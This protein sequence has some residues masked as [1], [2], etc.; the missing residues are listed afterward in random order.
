V[1]SFSAIHGEAWLLI[2]FSAAWLMGGI[3]DGGGDC[4]REMAMIA[5]LQNATQTY[6]EDIAA[7]VR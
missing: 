2:R 7:Q 5:R 3:R 4:A 1:N 6:R